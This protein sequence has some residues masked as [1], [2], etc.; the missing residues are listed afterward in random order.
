[1]SHELDLLSRL[2]SK[3]SLESL[4]NLH[5][6]S[7]ALLSSPGWAAG[8][9]CVGGSRLAS[10]ASPQTDTVE[11]LADVDNDTHDFVVGVVL[12]LL[13]NGS[14]EDVQPDV[15]VGL[16]LL[17]SVCPAATVLVLGVFPLGADA[18]LEEVVV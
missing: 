11:G 12:E 5:E 4:A 3:N 15:I 10:A 18:A 2:E 17:E 1:M 6:H 9:L 8:S 7:S 16:A 13:T 14:K